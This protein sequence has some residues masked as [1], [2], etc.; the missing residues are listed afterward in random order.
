MAH[1]SGT[2][3]SS[4]GPGSEE[5]YDALKVDP[6]TVME[7]GKGGGL[8]GKATL[9]SPRRSPYS[10][11]MLDNAKT[12]ESESNRAEKRRKSVSVVLEETARK[13]KY[14]L[15]ANDADIVEIIR[16]GTEE[17][18]GDLSNS[19][20]SRFTELV[21]TRQF[22]AFDRQNPANATSAFHGFF[23]LFWLATFLLLV[24][25]AANN[26][27]SYGSIFGRNEILRIMFHHDV[28]VLLA[29]DG[30]L[31]ASTVVSLGLQR[32]IFDGYLRWDGSGWILQHVRSDAQAQLQ[33]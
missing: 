29:S 25:I 22:T 24:K 17:A 8:E 12:R 4:S 20:R 1:S 26:W 14:L 15:S 9:E 23:T 16:R 19:R 2:P 6:S 3:S 30:I 13:G 10:L 21:F 33:A 28:V 32:L 7:G 18:I 11:T 5:D 27:K 31:C